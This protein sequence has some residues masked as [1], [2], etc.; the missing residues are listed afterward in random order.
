MNN[1]TSQRLACKLNF[2]LPMMMAD[3]AAMWRSDRIGEAY[4]SWMRTMHFTVRA[5]VPLM[6]FASEA[7]LARPG[8]PLATEFGAFLAR[9]IREEYGHDRWVAADYVEAG[10][11]AADLEDIVIGAD[12]A[13]MVGAQYYWIRHAHPIALLGHMAV[14]E[15]NPP[16]ALLAADLARRTGFAPSAFRA[17]ERH[18]SIDVRHGQEI[19]RLIDS[20]T[21]TPQQEALMGLSALATVRGVMALASAN[22]NLVG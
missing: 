8:D 19:T 17:L 14:L 20:L 11:A 7:C 6:L 22:G 3:L 2:V 15:G 5:T 21:F 16:S 1:T 9:H 4:R 10:G 13:A 18:S 12:V